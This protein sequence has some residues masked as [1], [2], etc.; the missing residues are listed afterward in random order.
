MK[1]PTPAL[2]TPEAVR[3]LPRWVP[4]LLIV[5]YVL[6]GF[7]GRDPWRGA[8]LTTL[9]AMLS[10]R[11][12]GSWLHPQVLGEAVLPLQWLPYWL[13]AAA[14]S[15]L[16]MLP[17]VVAAQLPFVAMLG[18]S[19]ACTWYAAY[20]LARQPTAQ[21]LTPAFGESVRAVDYARA[22][23]DGALLALVAT[24]GL[25]TLAHQISGAAVQLAAVSVLGWATTQAWR[26]SA[27]QDRRAWFL[28]LFAVAL[29]ALALALSGAPALGAALPWAAALWWRRTGVRRRYVVAATLAGVAA[30][31][32]ALGLAR[33]T[34]GVP[35]LPWPHGWDGLLDSDRWRS[36]GRL[37]AW[38]VWPSALLAL[39]ALWRWRR[40][41]TQPHLGWPLTWAG[42][43]LMMAWAEGGNDRTLLLALPALAILA[44]WALPTLRGS[45][46]AAVD[47]FALLF[48]TGAAI[49]VW[50]IWIAM[51]TGVP[52]KPAANVARL[53][54]G[55]DSPLH[56]GALA[57]ALAATVSWF[58][59]A[60]WRASRCAPALW[61]GLVLSASGLTLNW[62]L[63]M[64]LWLP[65]LNW[66]LGLR[67]IS[68]RV[69]ARV[70]P[71]VCLA[72]TG[73]SAGELGA[74]QLHGGLTLRRW[75]GGSDA[76]CPLLL[77]GPRATVTPEDSWLLRAD[78]ARLRPHRERW[79]LYE[80]APT[81]E[82]G[83]AP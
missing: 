2:V 54:P 37:L 59:V 40:Q 14:M 78:L 81:P 43:V 25:A 10:M 53:V 21:P 28:A 4:W 47:W 29:S 57:L 60:L 41:L 72:V 8:E 64:T 50:V 36:W 52:A 35:A 15:A 67:P 56:W 79:R 27:S 58:A 32:A 13:G 42:L 33:V 45:L 20:R 55:F 63:L 24:L 83:R 77:V 62:L 34:Y 65:L 51:M 5:A 70:P 61:K 16:P 3:R 30:L 49:I 80:R 7:V 44:A 17:P 46:A 66:G 74:L 39:L 48:Y 18:L 6:P 12:G 69:A 71:G 73:L 9:A 1:A 31:A 22:L 38:F 26:G 76:A 19:L 68:E 11:D 82:V 23:A 75:Q